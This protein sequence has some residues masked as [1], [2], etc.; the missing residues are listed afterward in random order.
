ML[1]SRALSLLVQ[2]VTLYLLFH[3][4]KFISKGLAGVSLLHG[5]DAFQ[6]FLLTAED[7]NFLLVGV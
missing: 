1:Q 4:V 6:S 7:L 3:S 2:V 5:E